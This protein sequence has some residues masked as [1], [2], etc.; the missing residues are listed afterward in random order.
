MR[1]LCFPSGAIDAADAAAAHGC[2]S[3]VALVAQ[4]GCPAWAGGWLGMAPG[5]SALLAMEL[6]LADWKLCRIK[7]FHCCLC[8]PAP[9]AIEG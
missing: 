2:P 9:I 7:A 5:G 1:G 4:G 8:L 3:P 6:S